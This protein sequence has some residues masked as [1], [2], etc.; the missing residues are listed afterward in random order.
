M[1]AWYHWDDKPAWRARVSI[2]SAVAMIGLAVVNAAIGEWST[3]AL[4]ACGAW[5][6]FTAWSETEH[7]S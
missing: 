1:S 7:G 6:W 5:G 4:A 2:L 3:A